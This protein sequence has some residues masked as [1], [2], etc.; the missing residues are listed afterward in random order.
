MSPQVN[1]TVLQSILEIQLEIAEKNAIW[2]N[3][4]IFL[5]E[6]HMCRK[7]ASH[8]YFWKRESQIGRG[9]I[10]IKGENRREEKL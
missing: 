5:V 8:S 4:G 7:Q 2:T 3:V 6:A 1:V 9:G 10:K